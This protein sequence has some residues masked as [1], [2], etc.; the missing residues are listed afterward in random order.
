M[1]ERGLT[2]TQIKADEISSRLFDTLVDE[3]LG[4]KELG[5]VVAWDEGVG[6]DGEADST[7]R[8]TIGGVP[9]QSYAQRLMEWSTSDDELIEE[10]TQAFEVKTAMLW[11]STMTYYKELDELGPVIDEIVLSPETPFYDV[12]YEELRKDTNRPEAIAVQSRARELACIA[13][14]EWAD[15][16]DSQRETSIGDFELVKQRFTVFVERHAAE[17]AEKLMGD[18]LDGSYSIDV[19]HQFV[20]FNRIEFSKFHTAREDETKAYTEEDVRWSI[21]LSDDGVERYGIQCNSYDFCELSPEHGI[22]Y[23]TLDPAAVTLFLDQLDRAD[24]EDRLRP[25]EQS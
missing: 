25:L 2:E 21:T 22:S 24:S 4:G 23:D 6:V 19:N 11:D 8:V 17:P 7:P 16:V 1:M 10:T 12:A 14:S 13:L 15:A 5:V 18:I 3:A 9:A 20:P